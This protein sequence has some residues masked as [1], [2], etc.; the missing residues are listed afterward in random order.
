MVPPL[1]QP[2][3]ITEP[4]SKVDA[5]SRLLGTFY[6]CKVEGGKAMLSLS[7]CGESSV[8]ASVKYLSILVLCHILPQMTER[9]REYTF[10]GP[11]HRQAELAPH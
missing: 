3:F 7:F 8:F 11:K 9:W 4:V 6:Q 10:L 2:E 5:H 1:A